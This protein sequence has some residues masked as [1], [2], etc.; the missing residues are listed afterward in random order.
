MATVVRGWVTAELAPLV[1]AAAAGAAEGGGSR[2][3]VAAAVAAAIRTGGDVLDPQAADPEVA[4]RE[5]VA[6]AHLVEKVTAGRAGE[7]PRHS[8]SSRAFR[9]WAMH[10]DFGQGVESVPSSAQEAKGR[11]RGPRR[12][13]RQDLDDDLQ[14]QNQFVKEGDLKYLDLASTDTPSIADEQILGETK[15]EEKSSVRE[16]LA[17]KILEVD[18]LQRQYQQH[19]GQKESVISNL[20]AKIAELE[21]TVQDIKQQA[22]GSKVPKNEPQAGPNAKESDAASAAKTRGQE[23]DVGVHPT[24]GMNAEGALRQSVNTSIVSTVTNTGL[25]KTIAS[26]ELDQATDVVKKLHGLSSVVHEGLSDTTS[27]SKQTTAFEGAPCAAIPTGLQED[28]G[29]YLT[30]GMNTEGALLP[31]VVTSSATTVI[32]TGLGKT[33][34]SEEF[35]QATDVVKA[36]GDKDPEGDRQDNFEDLHVEAGT[37]GTS[38]EGVLS[39]S[40]ATPTKAGLGNVKD[41]KHDGKLSSKAIL[42]Y[43]VKHENEKYHIGNFESSFVSLSDVAVDKDIPPWEREEPEDD[44]RTLESKR[45]FRE[46]AQRERLSAR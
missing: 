40:I 24:G 41:P 15:F 44:L 33:F 46:R 42:N 14:H 12:K 3:L 10:K 22:I 35:V 5:R 36:P 43:D 34:A 32:S 7:Q 9:N 21:R 19:I 6:R 13:K 38:M 20:L 1:R 11:A 39:Q 27:E 28:G 25:G 2:H 17:E 31:S 23:E 29:M 18:A 45:R 26:E 4:A 30:G 16:L 8:G 37:D